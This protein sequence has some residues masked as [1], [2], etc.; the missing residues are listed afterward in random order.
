M[1]R[2][3]YDLLLSILRDYYGQQNQTGGFTPNPEHAAGEL[4]SLISTFVG[5]GT[6]GNGVYPLEHTTVP[7]VG[8]YLPNTFAAPLVDPRQSFWPHSDVREPV[9]EPADACLHR[10]LDISER[11]NRDITAMRKMR[12]AISAGFTPIVGYA[13]R[14]SPIQ[15]VNDIAGEWGDDEELKRKRNREAQKRFRD[16]QKRLKN[17]LESEYTVLCDIADQLEEA[18]IGLEHKLYLEMKTVAVSEIILLAFKHQALETN[19]ILN[20]VLTE[21]QKESVAKKGKESQ[22]A[23]GPDC[24]SPPEELDTVSVVDMSPELQQIYQKAYQIK[25]PSSLYMYYREWQIESKHL[26]SRSENQKGSAGS[27]EIMVS[28]MNDLYKVWMINLLLYPD[29]FDRV[30]ADNAAPAE[31]AEGL[32]SFIS[33]KLYEGMEEAQIQSLHKEFSTYSKDFDNCDH[34]IK[35]A[36]EK[37]A[38]IEDTFNTAPKSMREASAIHLKLC[39]QSRI[40]DTLVRKSWNNAIDFASRFMESIGHRNA[41]MCNTLASP[42]PVDWISITERVIEKAQSNGIQL[43]TNE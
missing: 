41:F 8:P 26:H 7:P 19:S 25:E 33:D 29:N 14:E 11:A 28:R 30:F 38:E 42:Y 40:C 43:N 1:E 37:L 16:R 5:P 20:F 13:A 21:N 23:V 34:E 15:S 39:A 9:P 10:L 35:K 2:D 22:D 12:G 36:W 32:W 31:Q 4:A 27:E 6:N 17:D 3:K 24:Q 18:N